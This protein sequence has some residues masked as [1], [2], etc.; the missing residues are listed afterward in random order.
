LGILSL[1]LPSF[2]RSILFAFLFL[3]LFASAFYLKAEYEFDLPSELDPAIFP[4]LDDLGSWASR[5][6]PSPSRNGGLDPAPSVVSP[7]TPISMLLNFN[8]TVSPSLF[9]T[10]GDLT[11]QGGSN[12]S[13]LILNATLWDGDRLVESTRYMMIEVVPGECRGFDILESSRLS[14]ERGYSSRLEVEEPEELSVSERRDCLVVEDDSRGVIWEDIGSTPDDEEGSGGEPSVSLSSSG[15]AKV[16]QAPSSSRSTERYRVVA[17]S[18]KDI[19]PEEED[20]SSG[21]SPSDEDELEAEEE[22]EIG[23]E[24]ETEEKVETDREDDELVGFYYVGSTTS[25][26]YHRLDCRYAVKIKEENRI[27]FASSEEA[28]EAGYVPCKVCNPE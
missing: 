6:G 28:E 20:Q 8:S 24:V 12:L 17:D 5:I 25:N 10:W 3:A 18:S 4:L 21:S 1:R 22:V 13:Y 14:P 16:A 19:E 26:K 7:S 9:R 2:K 23:G 27:F 15:L 11:L